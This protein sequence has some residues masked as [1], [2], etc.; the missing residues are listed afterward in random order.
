M[1]EEER[2][3]RPGKTR[4]ADIPRECFFEVFARLPMDSRAPNADWTFPK[5]LFEPEHLNS[6][7]LVDC[8]IE[9]KDDSVVNFV[10]ESISMPFYHSSQSVA[11]MYGQKRGRAWGSH[12]R[13]EKCSI[14]GRVGGECGLFDLLP[15]YECFVLQHMYSNE[16]YC[17]PMVRHIW[18]ALTVPFD[19]VCL[20]LLQQFHV[21][22][23]MWC[24]CCVCVCCVCT[25]RVCVCIGVSRRHH[26]TSGSHGVQSRLQMHLI[27]KFT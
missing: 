12:F 11:L 1:A 6:E 4:P 14:L 23:C 22:V 24:M 3:W 27:P 19:P 25:L 9:K 20:F 8:F 16:C 5:P 2:E 21:C 15:K 13:R 7:A 17:S 10:C 26:P 18:D